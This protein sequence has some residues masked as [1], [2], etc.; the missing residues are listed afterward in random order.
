MNRNLKNEYPEMP[1]SFHSRVTTTLEN[2]PTSENNG[3]IRSFSSL[4]IVALAAAIFVLLTV[5][6]FGANEIY[7]KFV[8]KNN[9]KV[10]L[11]QD[12]KDSSVS[13]TVSTKN[14]VEYVKLGFGY[15]PDYLTDHDAPYKFGV[16]TDSGEDSASGL[17]FQLFDAEVAKDLEI[18]YVG[19][20]REC[21]FGENVGAVMKIDTGVES[22][23]D[24]FDK[25]FLISFDDFGYV[26][27]CYVSERISEEEMMKIANGLYLEECAQ[28]EAFIVDT[29]IPSVDNEGI[30]V[31]DLREY[32]YTKDANVRQ[33]GEKFDITAYNGDVDGND[34]TLTVTGIDVRDNVTGLDYS[35]LRLSGDVSDYVDENGNLKSYE[36]KTYNYGDG[37]NSIATI[38]KS[39]TIGRKIVIVDIEVR[40]NEDSANEF[41]IDAGVC[42]VSGRSD[43]NGVNL[44]EAS[45]ISGQ[46]GKSGGFFKVPFDAGECKT[47]SYG[48]ILDADADESDLMFIIGSMRDV[49]DGIALS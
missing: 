18:L 11:V 30:S 4:K 41:Y 27:R 44:F 6:A 29:Y 43:V 16:K 34:Y 1:D 24:G 47:V 48:F 19:S 35:S 40:N 28:S 49:R 22:D 14:K 8:E 10:T 20:V 36:R 38:E 23:G 7:K 32:S 42:T 31:P 17:T 12:E 2:L 13:D 25:Q 37:V 21:M 39:E 5:S 15:M 46:N 45:Y 3:K 33:I 26:L 9:Y